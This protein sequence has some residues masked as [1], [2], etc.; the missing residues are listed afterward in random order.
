MATIDR[1]QGGNSPYKDY[2]LLNVKEVFCYFPTVPNY[3]ALYDSVK[4]KAQGM[5]FIVKLIGLLNSF[6]TETPEG[7]LFKF[8]IKNVIPMLEGQLTMAEKLVKLYKL[9]PIYGVKVASLRTGLHSWAPELDYARSNWNT[10]RGRFADSIW[11]AVWLHGKQC[12]IH[13][14]LEKMAKDKSQA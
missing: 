12:Q 9:P 7:E 3:Q 10:S 5:V 2:N 1:P 13:Q 11:L 4:E 8:A 14:L 6:R